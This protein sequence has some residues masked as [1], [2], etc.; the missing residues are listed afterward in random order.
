MWAAELC[1]DDTVEALVVGGASLDAR[2][3]DGCTALMLSTTC[4]YVILDFAQ[5]FEP[6]APFVRGTEQGW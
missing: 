6:F 3:S 4:N 1:D 5:K 2:D